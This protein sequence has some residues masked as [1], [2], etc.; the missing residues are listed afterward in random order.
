MRN[1]DPGN[2]RLTVGGRAETTAMAPGFGSKVFHILLP[3][4]PSIRLRF[5]AVE[6]S[7]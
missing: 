1:R 6:M 4:F 5:T 3:G 2:Y 7:F